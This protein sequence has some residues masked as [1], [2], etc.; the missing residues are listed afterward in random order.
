MYSENQLIREQMI[1][2]MRIEEA[3]FLLG[4]F[5]EQWLQ[6][7][8]G[9]VCGCEVRARS[10]EIIKCCVSEIDLIQNF[11]MSRATFN[12]TRLS[13]AQNCDGKVALIQIWLFR[14]RPHCKNT[15]KPVSDLGSHLKKRN[16][17]E[18]KTLSFMWFLSFAMSWGKNYRCE[19]HMSQK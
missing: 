13:P 15:V 3:K 9:G 4:L 18:L 8:Y 6:L 7:L 11:R 17:S 5:V 10:G 16:K 1:M 2:R 12:H 14:L 19:S